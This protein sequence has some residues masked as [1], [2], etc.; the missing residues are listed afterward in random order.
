MSPAGDDRPPRRS[1]GSEG[2]G[3]PKGSGKPGGSGP[4]GKPGS[5]DKPEYTI[6]GRSGRSGDKRPPPPR[7]KPSEKRKKPPYRVYRSRPSLR[8]RFRKPS[9]EG[10]RAASAGGGWRRRLGRLLGGKRPWP[11]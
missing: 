1:G 5:G 3:K 11:R 10:L 2:R 6:Y 7:Q 9:L 4:K 8:D